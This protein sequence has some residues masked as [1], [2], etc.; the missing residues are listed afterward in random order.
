MPAEEGTLEIPFVTDGVG[1]LWQAILFALMVRQA[2][3]FAYL[4]CNCALH[5]GESAG[6]K[7]VQEVKK[8][9]RRSEK[10]GGVKRKE[11]Q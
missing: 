11:E 1:R 6:E 7:G 4:R 8:G 5:C 3:V 2:V 9:G 10:E